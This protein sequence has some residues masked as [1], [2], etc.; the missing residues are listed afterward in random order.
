VAST[1]TSVK[2]A[3]FSFPD[4]RWSDRTSS[5]PSTARVLGGLG[6][7]GV[8]PGR[9]GSGRKL[10][11]GWRV[12][13]NP[14]AFY[15]EY[16]VKFD[17]PV[18]NLSP[19]LTVVYQTVAQLCGRCG[20]TRLEYDYSVSGQSYE[21]VQDTDLLAQELDKF[22][23]T[24]I[25][26]HWK[27]GW[28]GSAVSDRIGGK[29]DTAFGTAAGFVSLDL[30]Q[31]FGV[32]QNIK[33]QQQRTFP[34]QKVSDAEYPYSLDGVNAVTDPSDPTTVTVNM[35][36]RNRSKVAVPLSRIVNTPDPFQLTSDPSGAL[37]A[38]GSGFKLVG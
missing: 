26:S 7:L 29:A 27:W 30:S 11:P 20:G 4:P 10:F 32:Y 2:G 22:L 21:T 24:R 35:T 15:D 5:L 17:E 37:A 28:L 38:A 19:V 8:V 13:L 16:I 23:F 14:A 1:T 12:K 33:Q 25:G 6:K 31:A 18:F 3:A 34:Q 36:V 9:V